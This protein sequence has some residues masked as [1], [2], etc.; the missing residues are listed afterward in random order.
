MPAHLPTMYAFWSSVVFQAGSYRGR[1][2]NAH[3]RLEGLGREHFARWLE[4]FRA[5]VDAHFAGPRAEA[6]KARASR[7]GSI[8]QV[9]LG[10][11]APPGGTL[12]ATSSSAS[13]PS[14]PSP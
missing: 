13:S 9:K 7:I 5:T 8:F 14:S 6:M 11:W 12:P 10:L 2:F 1:P 3:M 4:R